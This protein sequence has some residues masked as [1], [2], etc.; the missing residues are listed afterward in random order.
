[1]SAQP[2][3]QS[4]SVTVATINGHLSLALYVSH[5]LGSSTATHQLLLT[6]AALDRDPLLEGSHLDDLAGPVP[7]LLRRL[8]EA[9]VVP[10]ELVFFHE[11]T[12]TIH[13]GVEAALAKAL[14]ALEALR[15]AFYDDTEAVLETVGKRPPA[16]LNPDS[17][18]LIHAPRDQ[19]EE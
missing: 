4:G 13:P 15:Q 11:H 1:M 2:N 8:I 14:R 5:L 18:L 3:R 12:I 10:R 19:M 9:G 16:P 7:G 17:R 6:A